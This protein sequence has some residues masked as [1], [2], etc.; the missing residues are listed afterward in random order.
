MDDNPYLVAKTTDVWCTRDQ[1]SCAQCPIRREDP[2]E[3]GFVEMELLPTSQ[4]ILSLVSA[5]NRGQHAAL[6]EGLGVP[7]RCK[8]VE[9]KV[10]DHYKV[11]DVRLSPQLTV[12]GEG[13]GN[14]MQPALIVGQDL[15]L[16]V[17]YEIAGRVY[18]HPANQRATLVI[19]EVDE[20]V[21]S[22]STFK[23]EREE[24]ETLAVFRPEEQT[25]ESIE[26]KLEAIYDD[27]AANVTRIYDRPNLHFAYDLAFHS[28]LFLRLAGREINGWVNVMVAGDSAQGKSE[29]FLRLQ[30]HYALGERVECKNATVAG[31]LGGLQ[32]LGT[33]WFVSWGVIPT[34]DRRLV[35]LEEV[36]GAPVEVL[37]KLTDMRSS[38]VAEIPKFERRRAHS[39]T[40][41]IWISNPRG[42]RTVASYSFGVEAFS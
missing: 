25:V 18:P 23:P 10:R 4:A 36:K 22:L 9:F 12:S 6:K 40:R 1:P 20:T 30:Q 17:P 34:H 16:N 37:G 31:L 5:S 2:D 21:D 41:L 8:V 39:R 11:T 26:A 28:P 14:I 35:C 19:D 3:R 27:L 24:L 29:T 38:G 42:N 7:H 13:S 32:Q 33:R 15:D